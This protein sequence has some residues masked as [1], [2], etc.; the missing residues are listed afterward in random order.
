MLGTDFGG[1]EH[2]TVRL[3][4]N[5]GVSLGVMHLGRKDMKEYQRAGL[6][7]WESYR[8]KGHAAWGVYKWMMRRG[9]GQETRVR[10]DRLTRQMWK[11]WMAQW[12]IT[13]KAKGRGGGEGGL[14]NKVLDRG[15]R[16]NARPGILL[17]APLGLKGPRRRVQSLSGHLYDV[18]AN[19]FRTD[20]IPGGSGQ[21]DQCCGC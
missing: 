20:N 1:A 11:D 18:H 15:K 14:H 13:Q 10:L 7:Q 21:G 6:Q 5:E 16:E 12:G 4:M 19:M 2:G 9:R 17:Y 8:E 3:V